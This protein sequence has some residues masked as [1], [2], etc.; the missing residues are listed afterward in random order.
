MNLLQK[1]ICLILCFTDNF[2]DAV[3]ERAKI[4]SFNKFV[5]FVTKD[6]K[7]ELITPV[8]SLKR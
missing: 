2:T 5:P 3:V 6:R 8:S 1:Y 7:E 4:G